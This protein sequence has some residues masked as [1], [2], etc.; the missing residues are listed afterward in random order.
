[1]QPENPNDPDFIARI[2]EAAPDL[3]VLGGYGKILKGPILQVPRLMCINLHGGR[4]PKYRGSSP[5]NWAL[6]N[7]DKEFGISI[8]KVDTGVDTGDLLLERLFP[9]AAG[10]TIADLHHTVNARFPPLLVEALRGVRDGTLAPRKQPSGGSYYPLRFSEDGFVLWDMLTAE[11]AHNRIR[12]LTEP[13]P[14]AFSHYGGRKVKLLASE[15]PEEDFHGEPGRIYRISKKGVLVCAS[16]KCLWLTRAEFEDGTGLSAAAERYA[17]LDT[18]R[19]FILTS[20]A[21]GGAR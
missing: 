21:Q 11:Q 7:G 15:L 19:D 9:I 5:L 18:V 3:V 10:D 8:I 13:Y 1:M 16:D 4:L 12:A 20:I 2:R 17:K 14:C 6:I